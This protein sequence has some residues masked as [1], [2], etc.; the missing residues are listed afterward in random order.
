MGVNGIASIFLCFV[1]M[2]LHIEQVLEIFVVLHYSKGIE[3]ID[4]FRK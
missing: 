1:C 4:V 3:M 2:V